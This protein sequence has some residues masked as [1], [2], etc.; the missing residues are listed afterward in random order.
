MGNLTV[1]YPPT[2]WNRDRPL[3]LVSSTVFTRQPNGP[4]EAPC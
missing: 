3:P 1:P 4:H 2:D